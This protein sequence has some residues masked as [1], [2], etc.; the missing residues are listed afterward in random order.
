[1]RRDQVT[2]A[3]SNFGEVEI[4]RIKILSSAGYVFSNRPNLRQVENQSPPSPTEDGATGEPLG[5]QRGRLTVDGQGSGAL[6]LWAWR[7]PKIL[8]GNQLKFGR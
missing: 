7:F 5:A 6:K 3:A 1:M 4:F 2:G 8:P